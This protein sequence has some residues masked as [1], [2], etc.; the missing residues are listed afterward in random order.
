MMQ[1]QSTDNGGKTVVVGLGATGL[2]CL[3]FLHGQGRALAAMDS[4]ADPPGLTAARELDAGMPIVL[5]G[6]ERELLCSAT[7]VVVSP[8]VPADDPAL[9]DARAAGVP[10]IGEIELFA[11][12]AN[13]PVIGITGSNGKSTVTTLLGCMAQEAGLDVAVGGNLGTPAVALLREPV[14]DAYILELSSFQLETTFSLRPTAAV[15]LNISADHMD[16]H[17]SV[18]HYAHLKAGIYAG[19]GLMVLNADDPQVMA[20]ARDGRRR[21]LF[22]TTRPANAAD[23]GL[24][25]HGNDTWLVQGETRL[26]SA[27]SLRIRGQHN[28][29]NALAALALADA[30]ALPRA[31]SIAALK[32][33][34]GL[35][36]RTQW[37]GSVRG[38]HWY[39]D[40]KAT[41]VGAAMA[42]ISG[43]PGLL[44][45][46]LG[47]DG[48]GADFTPLRAA[49][50][51][52]VRAV[53]LIGRDA[54][55]IEQAL[56]GAVTTVHATDM[57]QAVLR[58]AELAHQEDNVL[59]SPACA[60]FDM[61]SGYEERGRVFEAAVG[62]L[63]S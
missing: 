38:V 7:E 19:D 44:V 23:Y 48:K 2:A 1:M 47:G 28:L 10:V 54:P 33:F 24:D 62:R 46:I 49:M 13:G 29:A 59:L 51:E 17:H 4:R 42:A 18:A 25:Q 57:D 34:P 63:A 21:I 61:F 35:P 53:V 60:S 41:N 3:R 37:V 12:N 5:G 32:T 43:M 11:R 55:V 50:S 40:S 8:G 27:S 52:R 20:M 6:F 22:S 9:E 31:S 30:M 45:L 39:N 15:V 36:H 16:R 58:A 56:D 14:P 26:V